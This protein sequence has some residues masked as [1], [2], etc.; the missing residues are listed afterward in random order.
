MCDIANTYAGFI[1]TYCICLNN[2]KDKI[3]KKIKINPQNSLREIC[4]LQIYAELENLAN[5]GK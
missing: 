4:F 5:S 2:F 1:I 3:K